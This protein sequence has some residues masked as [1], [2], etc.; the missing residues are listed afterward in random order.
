MKVGPSR[1]TV[2]GCALRFDILTS[3]LRALGRFP[4]VILPYI[5]LKWQEKGNIFSYESSSVLIF[6]L[7]YRRGEFL[8][9][10]KAIFVS[11]PGATRDC[12]KQANV[13]LK[14]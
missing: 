11:V 6:D 7:Q 10:M 4:N 2:K 14:Y 9:H 12:H 1:N 3:S 8:L 13:P 5:L